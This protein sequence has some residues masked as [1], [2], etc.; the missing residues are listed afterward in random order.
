MIKEKD[1]LWENLRTLPYFRALLRAVESR[2]YQKINF[3]EPILDIGC[4]DGHFASATFKRKIN[5]GFD[6]YFRNLVEAKQ[7]QKYNLILCAEG[8]KI[9]LPNNYFAS[10]FSNSVLEHILELDSVVHEIW[11]VLKPD[12]LF[13]FCVPNMNFLSHLSIAKLFERIGMNTI[14]E[15]YRHFFNRISRH[16]HNDSVEVWRNRLESAGFYLEDWWNY[17]SP[18]ALHVLEWGHYFGLPAWVLHKL[19]GRWVLAPFHWNLGIVE[20]IIRKYY[21]SSPIH[22]F[23]AYTFYIAK[24]RI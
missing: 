16:Y 7:Y 3:I 1:F 17:F 23:G 5:V 14:A 19:I 10:A 24:K 21:D 22:P 20:K 11:R 8:R 13:V 4:G 6:P 15:L 18:S 9:P 2:F 12:A